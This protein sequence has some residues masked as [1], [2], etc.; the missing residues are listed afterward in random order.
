MFTRYSEIDI[1]KNYSG[2]RFKKTSFEDTTMK[3]HENEM[4]SATNTSVSPTFKERFNH[5][6]YH[7]N[8]FYQTEDNTET[9]SN[10][11]NQSI[12]EQNSLIV[13]D[14]DN[15]FLE[16][17]QV[18]YSTNNSNIDSKLGINSIFDYLKDVKSDDLLIILL[19]IL[20]AS[21]KSSSNNDVIILL[22]LLLTSK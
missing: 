17:K 4:Q 11:I 8:K 3:T 22:A 14:K 6:D 21:D 9:V 2:N 7:A 20:L 1:P 13:D 10:E 15:S 19:I 18:N 16:E 5:N 12:N